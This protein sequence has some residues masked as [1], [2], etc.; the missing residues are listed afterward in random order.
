LFSSRIHTSKIC[1]FEIIVETAEDKTRI[2]QLQFRTSW[3]AHW[4]WTFGV[5]NLESVRKINDA[6]SVESSIFRRNYI[7]VADNVIDV[8]RAH[9]SREAEIADLNRRRPV[10]KNTSSVFAKISIQ[11]D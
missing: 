4:D 1:D 11:I 7:F 8:I 2:G 9:R 3:C 5:V 6:L 10:A